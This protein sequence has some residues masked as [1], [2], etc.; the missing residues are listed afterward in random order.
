MI[1]NIER[2]FLNEK[3]VPDNGKT[4][5]L[6]FLKQKNVLILEFLERDSLIFFHLS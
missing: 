5:S 2:D 6:E 4:N 1:Q 3:K